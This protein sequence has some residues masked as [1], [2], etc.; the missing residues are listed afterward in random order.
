MVSQNKTTNNERHCHVCA[1]ADRQ[2]LFHQQFSGLSSGSFMPFYDVCICEKCGFAFAD[3]LPPAES[4]DRYYAEMSKWEFLDNQGKESDQDAFRFGEVAKFL[5]EAGVGGAA[6]ALDIGC[7]TGGMLAV[8]KRAGFSRL[9]GLDPSPQCAAL[10]RKN[11]DVEVHTGTVKALKDLPGNFQLIL[12]SGVLE[13]LYDPN[14]VLRDIRG[15]LRDDGL[16]YVTVPDAARFAE[17]MDAPYQQFSLEHI[18]FFTGASLV[19]L[20]G[21]NGF[22]PVKMREVAYPYTLQYLYPGV[23]GLFKKSASKNWS[24]DESGKKGLETYIRASA[25]WEKKI[26]SQIADLVER[27]EPILV[28]GVGTNTQRLMATTLL[29]EA[30]IVAFVDSNPH[31]HGKQL[32]GRP[33][34]PPDEVRN[35]SEPILIGSIIYRDEISRQIREDL[36]CNNRLYCL[37][38]FETV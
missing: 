16:F 14:T 18:L 25:A 37:D 22:E 28:W 11:Y 35:H 2:V 19:N 13:H 1:S 29:K 36:K 5:A 4:F 23:E 30:N 9:L 8:L 34:V 24:R 32:Q 12:L 27:R 21:M 38:P 31:Y 3:N 17:Y 10:A 7:A 26:V 33:V 6:S 20:L 15:L